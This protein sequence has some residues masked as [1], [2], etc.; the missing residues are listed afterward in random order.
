MSVGLVPLVL[1]VLPVVAE[2]EVPV[3]ALQTGPATG[4]VLLSETFD[5][6]ASG[7]LPDSGPDPGLRL[8][9]VD[10]EYVVQK[11]IGAP[12]FFFM[13]PGAFSNAS[14]AVDVRL[15]GSDAGQVVQLWCRSQREAPFGG[16]IAIMR[17]DIQAVRLG[18]VDP[19]GLMVSDWGS[20]SAIAGGNETNHLELTCADSTISVAVNG[21]PVSMVHDET[22]QAG[23]FS[24]A[25]GTQEDAA[26]VR[27]DNLVITPR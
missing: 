8:G 17:P 3:V 13:L 10:G 16:Y 7:V 25:V 12:P 24:L 27:I 6:P 14:I 18:R 15:E 5:D 19:T 4:A 20:S 11:D 22:Y 21:V 23:S 2:D 9:Y 26:D 1:L